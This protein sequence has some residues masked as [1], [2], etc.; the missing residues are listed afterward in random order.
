MTDRGTSEDVVVDG[1]EEF[2]KLRGIKRSLKDPEQP[3][4]RELTS[5]ELRRSYNLFPTSDDERSTQGS[6]PD[7]QNLGIFEVDN[8]DID[9]NDERVI[10]YFELNRIE[11]DPDADNFYND[12][13]QSFRS[14]SLIEEFSDDTDVEQFVIDRN[15]Q[16][17]SCHR[18][19]ESATQSSNDHDDANMMSITSKAP[20]LPSGSQDAFLHWQAHG[21]LTRKEIGVHKTSNN[22]PNEGHMLDSEEE[23]VN[24]TRQDTSHN[25]TT[26]YEEADK[27]IKQDSKDEC[28]NNGLYEPF[29]K[30][31]T[32]VES[33]DPSRLVQL[34]PGQKFRDLIQLKPLG[35]KKLHYL[36]NVRK[37]KNNLSVVI[38]DE[39]G[40]SLLVTSSN[41]EIVLY[42]FDPLTHLPENKPTFRFDTKP[43]FTSTTDRLISTWPY[44]PHTINFLKVGEF[45]GKEILG[46]CMDDGTLMLWYS[47]NIFSNIK[48]FERKDGSS[49]Q[50]PMESYENRTRFYSLKIKPDFTLKLEASLWGLDT[51]SYSDSTGITHN[52][53]VASDNSQS[54]TLFYYHT[55]DERFYHI[56]THQVLH[57]I[58][59]V[60]FLTHKACDDT[61]KIEVSCVS[62]SGE[63]II[64]TFKFKIRSGPL[65]EDDL[66]YFKN[67]SVYYVDPTM[68]QIEN[69]RNNDQESDRIESELRFK[70]FERIHFAS[71]MIRRRVLLSEDCW[72]C[73][74]V[75]SIYFK[76]VQSI[77]A[78]TG[79]PWINEE[80]MA[81]KILKESDVLDLKYDP[82]K[83]SHLGISAQF[84]FFECPVV[85]FAGSS[86]E[87][88][89]LVFESAHATSIDDDYRRIHKGLWNIRNELR[90]N[91]TQK[92]KSLN[93]N[94]YWPLKQE[95]HNF[96]AVST[97]KHMSLFRSDTL[98]C[99]SATK[100]VFD[101]SIPFNDESKF[102]NRISISLV[103]PELLCFIGATQQGLV[104]IMRLCSHR[105][106]YAMR[107]EHIF[108]NALSLALGYQG[109]RTISGLAIRNASLSGFHRFFLYIVYTDGIVAAYEMTEEIS[110]P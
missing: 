36:E 48:E 61:H 39:Q 54:V 89:N 96:I 5:R 1:F 85:S 19:N 10:D 77:S 57:N 20:K 22:T 105:G 92:K 7:S 78:M 47:Q 97:S 49:L 80:D 50:N 4:Q 2:L 9:I 64:F 104:T 25:A 72:T 12:R 37:Y 74:P 68:A 60:S 40:N 109:Y 70:R 69:R 30:E 28:G 41:S 110:T 23:N 33:S 93:G 106:L 95:P 21:E 66:R 34:A 11:D 44:F 31:F 8:F 87:S 55:E 84:Q 90:N 29:R 82:V 102:S 91:N 108:P 3:Q 18:V 59:D 17:V 100:R 56:K 107:Q 67:E 43:A 51:R 58:P 13:R 15:I 94:T 99:N 26:E 42:G 101:L 6:I 76:E 71:P 79:D 98:F 27:E 73:R 53:I 103:I 81:Q 45:L 62:I 75:N 38:H 16:Y 32:T 24:I 46:A 86:V 14:A 83:T 88:Q 35:I 63:L 65:D 52:L